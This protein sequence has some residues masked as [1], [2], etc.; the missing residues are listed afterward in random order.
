MDQ[1]GHPMNDNKGIVYISTGMNFKMLNA[2]RIQEL[3]Q[4]LDK[5]LLNEVDFLFPQQE[6]KRQNWKWAA[7]QS[8]SLDQFLENTYHKGK[9]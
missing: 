1:W 3:E 4:M 9:I 7:S 6:Q 8:P 5:N 2:R